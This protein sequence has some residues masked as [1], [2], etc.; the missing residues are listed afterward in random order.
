MPYADFFEFIFSPIETITANILITIDIKP[1]PDQIAAVEAA[2]FVAELRS[3]D[4]LC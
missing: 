1:T 3:I 2:L 4:F